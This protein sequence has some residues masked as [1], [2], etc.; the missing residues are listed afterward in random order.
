[1]HHNTQKGLPLRLGEVIPK[2]GQPC[3]LC[4]PLVAMDSAKALV[5]W[6]GLREEIVGIDFVIRG[7]GFIT[8]RK[9]GNKD[10]DGGSLSS[11]SGIL[12]VPS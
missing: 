2:D 5:G 12:T 9:E 8:G 3:V 7:R 1:M 10:L 6:V 4:S 11:S